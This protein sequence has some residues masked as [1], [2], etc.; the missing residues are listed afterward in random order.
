M[1]EMDKSVVSRQVRM[2]EDA[3]PRRDPRR[4]A[5]RP[6]ARARRRL[7]GVE[8][9]HERA[10]AQPAAAARRARRPPRGRAAQLRRAAPEHR[11]RLTPLAGRTKA[12][13][14]PGGR[15]FAFPSR[16]AT[17]ARAANRIAA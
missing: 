11:Q 17:P 2:L 5:R 9:V 16:A 1:F 10:R 14:P 7:P 13:P 12:R 6:R 8:R 4:R 15:A 3:R